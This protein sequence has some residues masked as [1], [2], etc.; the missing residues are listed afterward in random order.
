MQ[1]IAALVQQDKYQSQQSWIEHEHE[2]ESVWPEISHHV[3]D[4][5]S[6]A[7][8]SVMYNEFWKHFWGNMLVLV[9]ANY[10]DTTL[11][12]IC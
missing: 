10:A 11:V 5:S 4:C 3:R 1:I 7:D 8:F 6:T 2:V 9:S 12:F